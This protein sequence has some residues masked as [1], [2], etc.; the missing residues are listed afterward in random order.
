MSRPLASSHVDP[1]CASSRVQNAALTLALSAVLGCAGALATAQTAPPPLVAE[2][3]DYIEMPRTP[4]SDGRSTAARINVLIEEPGA[5]R[6]FVAEH[7]GPLS[8][9]DKSTR[10]AVSYINFNGSADAPG[11]FPKFAPTGGF[12]SGLMGFAFDPDYRR[13]GVFYSLHLENPA[14]TVDG[15]PKAGVVSGLDASRFVPTKPISMPANGQ[16]LTREAVISEWSDRNIKNVTFE[17]TVREVMRVQLLNAI[18]PMS[19]LTFNPNARQGDAD[20]RVL[21]VSTG[22]GGT[23]ERNDVSRLNPQRLD[24]F[25]GTIIRIVPDLQAHVSTSQVSENGQYRIPN[26]NPFVST[27]GARKEIFAY[28]MRNPHRIAWDVGAGP[29]S[30]ASLLAFVIGSNVGSPVRYETINIV[31]RGANYGYPLRE[32][33]EFKPESP[34]TGPLSTDNTL[35]VRISDTVVLDQRIPM[36]DSALAYKTGVEGLAIANGFVYRGKRWPQLQGSV[37][38]GDITSG[39]L[40]YARM[41]DLIAAT[42]GNPTTLAAY[43]EITTTLRP[44]VEE[45]VRLN[46]NPPPP[47]F[48]AGRR[49]GPGAMPAPGPPTPTPTPTPAAEPAAGRTGGPPAPAA[50]G[51]TTPAP[52]PTGPAAGRTGGP[53]A[54]PAGAAMAPRPLRVELRIATDEAGEIYILTKSDGVIRRV[55]SIR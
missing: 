30:Q 39:R 21:Y 42:D 7:A 29:G 19:D 10:K 53:G 49:G 35:P 1:A 17:G 51:S 40:F 27:P 50:P 16:Q 38:F 54:G 8:I 55:M 44:L 52:A 20:W 34:I 47:G 37:V 48:G 3:A 36:Q 2:L 28:G 46:P 33:P 26:D 22:D 41:A 23:G 6:L 18:H 12:V 5:G 14:L 43:S 13:N 11:L 31:R 15:K 24:H 45:R 25:S 32:G 9:V 4:V